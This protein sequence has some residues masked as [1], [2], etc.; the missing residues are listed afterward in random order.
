MQQPIRKHLSYNI[1]HCLHQRVFLSDYIDEIYQ[2]SVAKTETIKT[3]FQNNDVTLNIFGRAFTAV[4]EVMT[5]IEQD[6]VSDK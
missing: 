6:K 1:N 3:V 4:A 5:A 2:N